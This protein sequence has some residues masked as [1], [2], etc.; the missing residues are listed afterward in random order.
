MRRLLASTL[1]IGLAAPCVSIVVASAAGADAGDPACSAAPVAGTPL[2]VGQPSP[3]TGVP[4]GG[5]L[6]LCVSGAPG[7]TVTATGSGGPAG[8]SGYLV[9]DGNEQNPGQT[10]GYTGVQGSAAPGGADLQVVGCSFGNYD[11]NAATDD[12][13]AG[14]HVIFDSANPAPPS[15][16][17]ACAF[18]IPGAG[19]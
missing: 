4:G 1:A 11:P 19:A 17:G 7:G 5:T 16:T 12:N 13:P 2:S 9:A 15:N 3:P 14:D 8:A 10:S 6:Q 18:P